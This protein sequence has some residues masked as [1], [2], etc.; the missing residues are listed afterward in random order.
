MC[1]PFVSFNLHLTYSFGN[2][3]KGSVSGLSLIGLGSNPKQYEKLVTK[4][5]LVQWRFGLVKIIEQ[6]KLELTPFVALAKPQINNNFSDDYLHLSRFG[7][8]NDNDEPTGTLIE[9]DELW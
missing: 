5:N 2:I 3:L 4:E 1:G 9:I 6:M 7:E 8:W